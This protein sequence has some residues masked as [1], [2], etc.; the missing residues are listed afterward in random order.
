MNNNRRR[1]S[2]LRIL[3]FSFLASF[4]VLA[5]S[6]SRAQTS[7]PNDGN[8]SPAELE[9]VREINLA[10]ANP[11]GYAAH[12]ERMRTSYVGNRYQ[13]SGRP[14]LVTVEGVRV[15][16]E[17][18]QTLRAA[19]PLLAFEVSR[20]LTAAARD[21]ARD[22]RQRG[23]RGHRGSDGSIPNDR[24]NRY[25]SFT[26]SI[27]EC[28]EYQNESARE[29]VIK[30]LI[31]DGIAT[32]GHRNSILSQTYRTIGVAIGD[33]EGGGQM[34]VLKLAGRFTERTNAARPVGSTGNTPTARPLAR[35]VQRVR[36]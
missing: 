3:F 2:V 33:C 4:I 5:G 6:E 29:T 31:D 16:N 24:A 18:I 34:A 26:G 12:L 35:P 20:G 9:I 14:A 13:P 7:Q 32:R 28:I 10:R 15:L 11:S 25:G 27:G 17:A 30:W 22:L 8:L 21:H 19:R 1:F 23:R 36:P